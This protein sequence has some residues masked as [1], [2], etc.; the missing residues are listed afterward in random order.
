M[1]ISLKIGRILSLSLNIKATVPQI[2]NNGNMI[3]VP[4]K[5]AMCLIREAIGVMA[6]CFLTEI[7]KN[8]P[9]GV[10]WCTR[11]DELLNSIVDETSDINEWK[12]E[13]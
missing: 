8:T 1:P 10:N 6:V 3:I 11:V 2:A 9:E 13:G 7:K 4:V 5:T 12:N